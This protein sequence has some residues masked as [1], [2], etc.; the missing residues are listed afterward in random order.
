MLTTL[1]LASALAANP[2]PF[3]L[4]DAHEQ[5]ESLGDASIGPMVVASSDPWVALGGKLE[6]S[7]RLGDRTELRLQAPLIG[8]PGS[9]ERG[10]NLPSGALVTGALVS[11]RVLAVDT[12][13]FRLAPTFLLAGYGSAS[14]TGGGG[15]GVMP[16]VGVAMEG[17]WEKVRLDLSTSLFGASRALPDFFRDPM[18]WY[19]PMSLALTEAGVSFPIGEYNSLRIGLISMVPCVRWRYETERWFIDAG[20]A[21]AGFINLAQGQLGMRF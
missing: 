5:D 13:H 21:S 12:P 1:L 11:A 18:L 17:G 9:P 6:A 8:L 7:L 19:P 2:H 20:L 15:S 4:P 3:F 16:M 10:S 14:T